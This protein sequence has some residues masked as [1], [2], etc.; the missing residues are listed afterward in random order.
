MGPGGDLLIRRIPNP[1]EIETVIQYDLDNICQ[2][3]DKLGIEDTLVTSL[4]VKSSKNY[5]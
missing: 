4:Y 2:E 5:A 3:I 1:T